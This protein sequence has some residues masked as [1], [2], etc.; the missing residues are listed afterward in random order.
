[1]ERYNGTSQLR[2][3]LKYI[4]NITDVYYYQSEGGNVKSMKIKER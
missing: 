3:P 1:M 2:E 4:V